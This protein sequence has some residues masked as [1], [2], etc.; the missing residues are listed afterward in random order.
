[1]FTSKKSLFK[2]DG[3]RVLWKD[4]Y[5]EIIPRRS[6]WQCFKKTASEPKIILNQV[7]GYAEPG[8][9]TFIMGASGAG[10]TTLLNILTQRRN[11]GLHVYGDIS[12]N[13]M[14]LE[15]GDMKALSAYVQQ[16]DLFSSQVTVEE[17]LMFAARLR[18]PANKTDEERRASVENAIQEMSLNTCRNNRVGNV[19]SKSLSRSERKR[20]AFATEVLT[21]PGILFCDEPTSGLDSFMS[22]QVAVSLQLLASR[23]KTVISTIHQPSSQVYDMADSLIL[24]AN[25]QVV[26]QGN[27]A[28][29]GKF[30]NGCG[31]P[32]PKYIGLPDHF[33]KVVSRSEQESEHDYNSRVDKIIENFGS[34]AEGKAVHRITHTLGKTAKFNPG[35]QSK[36]AASWFVQT[37]WLFVRCF[38]NIIR[39]PMVLFVR[40]AQVVVISTIIGLVYFRTEFTKD[41]VMNHKGA[42]FRAVADMTFIF[43]FPCIYVFTEEIPIVV[44]EFQA[45]TYMP[46]AYYIALNF[47]DTV[48]YLLL[49]MVYSTI[50]YLAAGYSGLFSQ[51][52]M[53]AIL[54]IIVA[55]VAASVAYAAACIFGS[56]SIAATYLPVITSPFL[57]FAGFFIDLRTIPLYF[58]FLTHLSWFKY[59]YESHLIILLKPVGSIPGCPS[60]NS[61]DAPV[62]SAKD[63][64]ELLTNLGFNKNVLW[65]N[66]AILLLMIVLI[67]LIGLVAF[68]IR[69]RRS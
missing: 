43:M 58:K 19:H 52:I 17:Q 24:M 48:Q 20:L 15:D 34:S 4:I 53:F 56:L 41:T 55:N 18:M 46:S 65:A 67:R 22:S 5:A 16:E 69:I 44:R 26:Y 29:V 36:Y 30:F 12:I 64:G 8:Q 37:R 3:K 23:G 13:D 40:L 10:K 61:H 54:N 59:A 33:M 47:A 66:V 9:L 14:L 57:T 42:A 21:D 27:A 2:R 60:N 39:N 28:D 11:W 7:S 45:N 25:C 50:V 31:H 35:E 62:C 1:M 51:F 6:V 38:R 68:S 32:C 49:P 63:G